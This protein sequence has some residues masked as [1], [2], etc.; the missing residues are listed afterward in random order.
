M[1][2]PTH[3]PADIPAD[4]P[5]IVRARA[6]SRNVH[7][8]IVEVCHAIFE[9]EDKADPA[10]AEILAADPRWRAHAIGRAHA[11]AEH[12]RRTVPLDDPQTCVIMAKNGAFEPKTGDGVALRIEGRGGF[13]LDACAVTADD[14]TC[15]RAQFAAEWTEV[16]RHGPIPGLRGPFFTRFGV[17]VAIVTRVL[18]A[19]PTEDPALLDHLRETV[20]DSWRA[21]ELGERL[22][23]LRVEKAAQ[24]LGPAGAGEDAP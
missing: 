9:P 16:I 6:S 20:H 13:D 7:P 12:V 14:G 5:L 3:R 1:F 24:I 8:E 10:A 18:P 17:H 4:D 23:T 21:R 2:E 19:T 11:F 22:Q 15:E